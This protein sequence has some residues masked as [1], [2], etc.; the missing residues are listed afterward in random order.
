MNLKSFDGGMVEIA[1]GI[2]EVSVKLDRGMGGVLVRVLALI[3]ICFPIGNSVGVF[4][5][6]SHPRYNHTSTNMISLGYMNL[7]APIHIH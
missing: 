1:G 2:I 7:H 4:L 5:Y 3:M 6:R